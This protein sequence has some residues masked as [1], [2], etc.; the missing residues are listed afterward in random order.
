M[1][2]RRLLGWAIG[3][4]TFSGALAQNVVINEIHY[5]PPGSG[6]NEEFIEFFNPGP[7]TADLTGWTISDGV[8]FAF[9]GGTNISAGGYLVVAK[10]PAAVQAA[11]GYAGALAWTSGALDNSGERVAISN[12]SFVVVDQVTYDDDPPWTTIPDGDGPSLEL[13][14]PAFDNGIAQAWRASVGNHG[15]PGAQNSRYLAGPIVIAESPARGAVVASL[16]SV[17]VTFA[18][19]VVGVAAG[20][21]TVDGSPAASVSGGG[22]GP[23][24]F[25]GFAAPSSGTISVALGAGAIQDGSGNPFGGDAWTY[26]FDP[27]QVVINEIHYHPDESVYPNEEIE[28]LELYNAEAATVDLSG[29]SVNDA[30][31]HVFAP[32]TSIAAGGF[33]VLA[34]NP[35]ALQS[36]TGFAGAIAWNDGRLSNGGERLILRNATATIID[37]VDYSDRGA[38]TRAADGDGPSLELTNPNLPNQYGSAWHASVAD[39][40]TPG[41]VNSRFVAAPPPIIANVRH[42]PSI[43]QANQSVSVTAL[44]LDDVS[45]QSV[46]L[47]YRQDQNPTVAYTDA[48]M[49]DDGAHGDG[50]AGDGVYGVSV[51]GLANDARLDFYVSASDG[52][53]TGET[54]PGHS[55]P[56][57]LGNPS[58]TFLCRFSNAAAP[59]DFPLYSIII[60]EANRNRQE[61]GTP[62]ENPYDATFIGPDGTIFY[63]VTERYRGQSSLFQVPHSYRVDF[64]DDQ[65]LQSEMGFEITKLQVLAN[66]PE[67]QAVGY[68]CF[69]DAGILTP[70]NQFVRINVNP[71]SNQGNL[72]GTVYINVERQDG[73]MLSR[74]LDDNEDDGNLYRGRQDGDLRW[75]GPTVGPGPYGGPYRTLSD[76]TQGYQ[77]VTNF[78]EDQWGDLITLC[79]ALTCAADDGSLCVGGPSYDSAWADL[80]ASLIDEDEWA[81]YFAINAILANQEGGIYRDTGDD[82]LLYFFLPSQPHPTLADY[83]AMM[84]PID[85]DSVL[86]AN[87][88]ETMWRCAVPAPQRVLRHNAFAP[89]FVK[90][91]RDLLDNELSVAN[92]HAR[93]DALPSA[94]A[95]ATVKQDLRNYYSTRVASIDS[96]IVSQLSLNGVPPSPYTSPSATLNLNGTLN[97]AGTHNVLVNGQPA[98]FSVYNATWSYTYT[99]TR[100]WNHIVVQGMDR[101]GAELNRVE[102]Y[103]FFDPPPISMRLVCPTR[104][105]N[106]K[107]LS[108]KAEVLD[109]CGQINWRTWT[110]QGAVSATRVSNGAPVA[111]S[112]VVFDE[113]DGVPPADSVRFYNGVGS[114]SITLDNGAAEPA[115]DID[116]TVTLGTLSATRRVTILDNPPQRS[117]G[118]VLGAADLTWS[119]ADGVIHIT[120]TT[121][122]PVGQTLT[123]LPGTLIMIDSGAPGLGLHIDV[124]GQV[125]AVGTEAEPIYFFPTGAAAAMHLTVDC[126]NEPAYNAASWRGIFHPQAGASVYSH[127]FLAGAGN[128][129]P[130]GHTRPPV[131]TVGSSHSLTMDDCVLI[132]NPGK[133]IYADGSGTYTFHRCLVS[134][135]GFGAEFAGMGTYT[136]LIED[137][138]FTS[139]GHG[140]GACDRDGDCLNVRGLDAS[141]GGPKVVRGGVYTDTNDDGI[142]HSLAA[143]RLENLIVYDIRD[144][145]ITLDDG[146]SLSVDNLLIF[147]TRQWGIRQNTLPTEVR[148]TTVASP[149]RGLDTPDCPNALVEQVICWPSTY[150]SCCGTTNYSLLGAGSNVGCGIGNI[151]ADPMFLNPAAFY[152]D[153]QPTSPAATAGP[154]GTPI[155]WLGTIAPGPTIS[156]PPTVAVA[157][158]A[159]VPAPATNLAQFEAQGG[160]AS[161]RCGAITVQHVGDELVG[162]ACSGTIL[163]TYRATD[164]FTRSV[165]CVQSITLSDALAPSLAPCPQDIVV[166]SPSGATAVSFDAPTATDNC[167]PAPAV[168]CEPPSGSIFPVG[169]TQVTCTATDAC[170]NSSQCFFNVTVVEVAEITATVVLADVNAPAPLQRCIKFVARDAGGCAAAVHALVTFNGSPATG[171]TTI[172]LPAGA[173]TS[174]CGKDE[175]HTLWDSQTLNPTGAG[176]FDATSS[177]VLLGGDTDND[178]DVDND[179]LSFLLAQEGQPAAAGGCPWDGTRDADFS[180]NGGVL[181]EDFTYIFAHWNMTSACTCP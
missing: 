21:L 11:T 49:F 1:K 126:V 9:P 14:N 36:A 12:A 116:V 52:A 142:D 133:A 50:P 22:A 102:Q 163:R 170:N 144:K 5:N 81:T 121:T 123:I 23:Y 61:T 8:V 58:Q 159:Q 168:A 165:E 147:D 62:N 25:S 65:P 146:G 15:T 128:G 177:L 3:A 38:W 127:V 71:T 111:T 117:F 141:L 180:N 85:M 115:G 70:A 176:T 45:V 98:T 154:D 13:V 56:D 104:M 96:Q 107:T 6:D 160:S 179:D 90:R 84:L 7:G 29:W 31:T 43:P 178:G 48:A 10:I 91:I 108:L 18:V 155:G 34:L 16:G 169:T 76:D 24:T 57:V 41:A 157:C 95:S 19:G 135:A 153:L 100:G 47:H 140:P 105:V 54:P 134:R 88:T 156:C 68:G 103:V 175:Q 42:N 28:F 125:S 167:D 101:L 46:T 119:P 78:D 137:C 110:G 109:E 82:F 138:W 66:R 33:V 67:R 80:V 39:A 162:T 139:L 27:P 172:M 132:D 149:M 99:L 131:V 151:S 113:H 97:Q 17:D 129:P 112:I 2:A 40:G 87:L 64:G 124:L 181:A 37:D 150:D 51:A 93:I 4:A 63:N 173:W 114:V 164:A 44:V 32:G 26:E 118:G 120:G 35:A 75:E 83:R 20:D 60:T 55:T 92:V 171:T 158:V 72:L 94:V 166:N 143:L 77:K 53:L 106:T 74:L 145:G 69:S 79:D 174:V 122:V 152:Y 59:G 161:A 73:D 136:L 86:L 30:I 148:N 89:I 130:N